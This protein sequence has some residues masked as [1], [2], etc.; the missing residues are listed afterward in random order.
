MKQKLWIL[1]FMCC[2]ASQLVQGSDTDS[3]DTDSI[4]S[5]TDAVPIRVIE[6]Y[7]FEELAEI[8]SFDRQVYQNLMDRLIYFQRVIYDNK[9]FAEELEIPLKNFKKLSELRFADKATQLKFHEK[10]KKVAERHNIE[11]VSELV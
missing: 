6:G 10:L 11:F 1:V 3:S 7:N 4:A 5:D 2:L 8:E 9:L